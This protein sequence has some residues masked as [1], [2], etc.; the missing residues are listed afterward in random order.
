M[1]ELLP[2]EHFTNKSVVLGLGNLLYG[3]E[4]FGIHAM[5]MLH[6]HLGSTDGLEFV[7]GG[8]LGLNLL[9]LVESCCHLLLLDAIDAGKPP[10][11]VIE[12]EKDKIPLL[13]GVK[14]SEHQLGFQ[15]VL[16]LASLRENLQDHLHLVGVQPSSLSTGVGLS[17]EVTA[18]LSEVI[19]KAGEVLQ[20]WGLI[21][22]SRQNEKNE[23]VRPG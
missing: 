15:E 23:V 18:G 19:Q 16:A 11:T 8:V 1:I 4:G 20:I 3:D 5:Q 12:L 22:Y 6:D 17:P 21:E 2:E 13:S 9:P 14:L 10:G 7:D